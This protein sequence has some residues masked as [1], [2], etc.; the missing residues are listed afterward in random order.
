METKSP[1]C[2]SA[3]NHA[4][5]EYPDGEIARQWTFQQ[6]QSL[7]FAETRRAVAL[8]CEMGTAESGDSVLIRVTLI[9][10]FTADVLLDRLVYP[11][12][13]MSHYNTRYSGI[14]RKD[15]EQA[16]YQ[17]RCLRGHTDARSSAWRFIGPSTIVIGHAVNNDLKALR[18]IHP[19][20]VDTLL[21]WSA[22][23]DD[24]RSKD[25]TNK[26]EALTSEEPSG[27]SQVLGT[28]NQRQSQ[29]RK[30]SGELTLKYLSK[31]VLGREIQSR[32]RKGHDSYED[33]LAA[34]DLVH[35]RVWQDLTTS[36]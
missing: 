8:D 4:P 26:E 2:C 36:G 3:E 19:L 25:A 6:T 31:T 16:R 11:D 13:P 28:D 24:N 9:D 27:Q 32:G 5:K 35:W 21:L 18:L 22:R 12:V 29:H 20:V 17:G 30:G 14:T 15:M 1:P 7:N 33:A 23:S 10:Y 34:R